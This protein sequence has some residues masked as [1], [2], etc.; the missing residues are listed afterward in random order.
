MPKRNAS[1]PIAVAA[2]TQTP[3]ATSMPSHGVIAKC[4][5]SAAAV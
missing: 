4:W 5:N 1:Q 3:T 2:A